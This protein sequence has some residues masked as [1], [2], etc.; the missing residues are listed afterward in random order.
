MRTN[1]PV[2][3]WEYPFPSGK[4]LVSSTDTKGRIVYCNDAFVEVSGFTMDELL[5]QPHNLVRHPDM[6]E[7]AY[8]DMWETIQAGKP[9]SAPVKN[10]RQDGDHYWVMANVTPLLQEGQVVGY[11]SVR[12]E[13]S[14]QT[15]EEAEKLYATMR[16]E[17]RTGQLTHRLQGGRLVKTHA[18]GRLQSAFKLSL[19]SKLMGALLVMLLAGQWIP[20]MVSDDLPI[21]W[22]FVMALQLLVLAAMGAY[23]HR[24]VVKPLDN[25]VGDLRTLSGCD[26]TATFERTRDDQVG[27]I[28]QALNQ[29]AM[30]VRA[31][32]RDAREQ[33]ETMAHATVEMAQGNHDLSAR[34][35]VQASS[36]E[37]TAS[38]MSEMTE[39]VRQSAE[40]AEQ[41]ATLA[42]RSRSNVDSSRATMNALAE[43]MDAIQ[44]AS[45]QI[46]EIT[47]LIDS[48]AFQTNILALN[49]AVEAARAGDQG[50][51]FAVVA[52]EVRTLAQRSA[53]AAKDIKALIDNS[54]AQVNIGQQ[55]SQRTQAAF[56]EVMQ[57][58]QQVSDAVLEIAHA[59][60][61]QL[62][63]ISQVNLA[64]TQLDEITQHNSALVEEM[65]ASATQLKH[66]AERVTDSVRMFRLVST[67]MGINTDAVALR[68]A[69]QAR[70]SSQ[71]VE[72]L[73]V[74]PATQPKRTKRAS[75]RPLAILPVH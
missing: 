48:I 31:I 63:G 55:L 73:P 54:V 16:E 9:W 21:D 42:A 26:L 45:S 62:D 23:V 51:G 19:Q 75:P 4:T 34:T 41:S 10:R 27:D 43:N 5:G 13:A 70:S 6:P 59:S 1:L 2:S 17:A 47:Q 11:M 24:L 40:S 52:G 7:E 61:E 37:Q 28:Q 22:G 46:G 15:I 33:A 49:A 65:A 30:N 12:S 44:N 57:D 71:P 29:L 18:F 64:V 58:V 39:A 25:L 56:T 36:L 53:Q 32:V 3:G 14:R 68:K 74:P 69:A 60:R 67:D 72:A 8:R 38:S 50:R 35:E 20:F 66:Q